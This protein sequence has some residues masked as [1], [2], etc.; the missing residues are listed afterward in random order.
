MNITEMSCET[1]LDRQ[2]NICSR[3]IGWHL[4]F[5]LLHFYD[6]VKWFYSHYNEI[7]QES[8]YDKIHAFHPIRN[9]ITFC[10][11]VTFSL[12]KF[13]TLNE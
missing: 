6:L 7:Y 1:K 10:L 2:Q 4:K 8:N 12:Q 13:A 3:K 5:K 11:K 9:Q